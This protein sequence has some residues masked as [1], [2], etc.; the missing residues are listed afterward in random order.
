MVRWI[1]IALLI[2]ACAQV[3]TITGGPADNSAPKVLSQSIENKACNVVATEQVLVFDE[4]IKLDQAPQRILLMPADSRLSFEVKAKQLCIKFEDPLKAKTTYT[5]TCNGA[6][7]DI[8][9]LDFLH[10]PCTRFIDTQGTR[11][12]LYS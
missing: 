4:F 6:I 11:Q 9:D 12:I 7:K 10:R 2:S 8:N 3:G 5:L 1:V